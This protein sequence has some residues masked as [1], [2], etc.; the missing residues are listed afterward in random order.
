[1]Q[2]GDTYHLHRTLLTIFQAELILLHYL[3]LLYGG[4][5]LDGFCMTHLIGHQENLSQQQKN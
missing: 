1:M 4:M 2:H 5:G 3:Q